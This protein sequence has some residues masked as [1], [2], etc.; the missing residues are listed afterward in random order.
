MDLEMEWGSAILRGRIR[1]ISSSGMF[2]ELPDPLWVGAE[3]AARIAVEEKEPLRLDCSVKRVEP[4]HG[5]G[6][7]VVP[8]EE[9]SRKRFHRFLSELAGASG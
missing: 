3:F 2:I 5:M 1:D 6:V 4:E 7:T 9:E 8:P